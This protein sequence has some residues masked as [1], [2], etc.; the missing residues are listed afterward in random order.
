MKP[1]IIERYILSVYIPIFFLIS[2]LFLVFFVVGDLVDISK[3]VITNSI[4]FSVMTEYF[5]NI[6]PFYYVKY[7]MPISNLLAVFISIA[8]LMRNNELIAM[9]SCGL[10]SAYIFMPIILFS[11]LLSA[12]SIYFS[13]EIIPQ[14]KQKARSVKSYKIKLKEINNDVIYDLFLNVKTNVTVSAE[15]FHFM[16]K[17]SVKINKI[18][19][20]ESANSIIKMRI[21]ADECRYENFNWIMY[22]GAKRI[23]SGGEEISMIPFEKFNLSKELGFNESPEDIYALYKIQN[24]DKDEFTYSELKKYSVLFKKTGFQSEWILTD[25]YYMLSFPLSNVILILFGL[26]IAVHSSKTNISYGFGLSLM[27]CFVFWI[28]T[29]ICVALGHRA[30]LEPIIATNLTNFVF[31]IL[32]FVLNSYLKNKTI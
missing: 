25:L 23:W 8:L 6:I 30:I 22:N 2:F 3:T 24:I 1:K 7:I 10:S 12:V 15:S 28:S 29:Y 18:T 11:I 32:S 27:I 19:L 20:T 14:H 17:T 13:L 5:I 4:D 16:D 31:F 26:P 9:R 21:D